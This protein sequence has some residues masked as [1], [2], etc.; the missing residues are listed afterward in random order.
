MYLTR[1]LMGRGYA[2]AY[3]E[4]S[5]DGVALINGFYRSAAERAAEYFETLTADDSRAVC[6]C[7][8]SVSEDPQGIEVRLTLTLRE[9]GRQRARKEL[10]HRWER[11]CAV[12]LLR[13]Q[14]RKRRL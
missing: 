3:P 11:Q 14:R 10:C 6:R 7:F 13:G 8:F 2:V 12:L 9:G 4:F 1:A 5:G